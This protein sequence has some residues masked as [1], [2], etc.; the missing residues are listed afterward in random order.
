MSSKKKD[1]AGKKGTGG[2][3]EASKI[4]DVVPQQQSSNPQNKHRDDWFAWIRFKNFQEYAN[5]GTP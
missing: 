5:D 1:G 3:G 2:K 4:K